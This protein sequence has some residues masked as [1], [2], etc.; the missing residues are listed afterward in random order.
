MSLNM[1]DIANWMVNTIKIEDLGFAGRNSIS[2]I[3]GGWILLICARGTDTM[4]SRLW[5][6]GDR[7][8]YAMSLIYFFPL[9]FV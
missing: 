7:I 6:F 9:N 1:E 8:L 3:V 2:C 4:V 5:F